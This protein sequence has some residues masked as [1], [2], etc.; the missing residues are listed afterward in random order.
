M[1][2]QNETDKNLRWRESEKKLLK[3]CRIFDLYQVD[4]SSPEGKQG[5]FYLL[6]A[7]DWV[8]VIPFWGGLTG[9]KER[10]GDFMMVEQYRHG[11]DS[12]SI[13]FPAG[14]VEA[15]EEP[16]HCAERELM[17]ETGCRAQ[18]M[19]FLGSVSPNP[20]FMN[21]RVH[22]YLACGLSMEGV[23]HLDEHEEIELHRV[24]VEDVYKKMGTGVYNNGVM[25]IA[26]SFLHRYLEELD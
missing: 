13:E 2:G 10:N 20:A 22:L 15:G 17:E 16:A 19:I 12:V 23:Q 6:D 5:H 26:L 8:T 18:Q 1:S 9:L 7:P 14:T 3:S 24:S 4:R 25:M 21:N 11:S